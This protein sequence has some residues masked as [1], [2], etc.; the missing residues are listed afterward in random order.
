MRVC[1]GADLHGSRRHYAAMGELVARERADVVVLGGDL[2]ADGDNGNPARSQVTHVR[3]FFLPTIAAWRQQRPGLQVA[4]LNGNH[5]WSAAREELRIAARAGLLVLLDLT[6]PWAF[7]GRLWLGYHCTPWTPHF[8]KDFERRDLP[9]DPLPEEGG[10]VYDPALDQVRQVSG[11]VHYAGYASLADELAAAPTLSTPWVFVCHAPP[12]DTKLDRLPQVPHPIGSR[13]VRAFIAERQPALSLHGHV[14]ESPDVTGA[15]W[16]R[17][18][19]T[20]SVNPGQQN[21]QL[22]AVVFEL[23]H[24]AE[25]IHHTVYG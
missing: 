25:T 10:L 5:D 9:D 2:F 22:A 11:P 16:E 7:G 24:P 21:E 4:C 20:V 3:N 15:Y 17:L 8:V 18:G 19:T 1:F 13:A 14:H 12:Y 23:E 6:T